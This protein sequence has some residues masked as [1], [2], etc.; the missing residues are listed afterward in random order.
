MK[1]MRVAS[2]GLLIDPKEEKLTKLSF[3][4]PLGTEILSAKLEKGNLD[5][6]LWF[7]YIAP[8]EAYDDISKESYPWK[9]Y[10]FYICECT[11]TEIEFNT[12]KYIGNI[13]IADNDYAVFY[14]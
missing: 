6:T 3:K 4:L 13:D 12:H 8:S 9:E 10:N 11:Y 2:V 14:E 7:T 1:K 5:N